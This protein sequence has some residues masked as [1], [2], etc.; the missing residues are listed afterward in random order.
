LFSLIPSEK[1]VNKRANVK[2]ESAAS[3]GS[4]WNYIK[5]VNFLWPL[6][7]AAQALHSSECYWLQTNYSYTQE[8][9]MSI[10]S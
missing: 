3:T 4:N 2:T 8:S 6:V 1:N 7:V 5:Y 10:R 9:V